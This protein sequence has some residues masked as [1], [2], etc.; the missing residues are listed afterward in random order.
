MEKPDVSIII[1]SFNSRNTILKTLKSLFR[2]TYQGVYEV[3]VVDSSTDGTG[4]LIRREFPMVRLFTF[5]ERKF[6]G[7]ARN[8]G[9]RQSTGEIIAFIDADCI[10]DSHWIE[11]IVLAHET[12][13]PVIGGAVGNGN[14][15]SYVGWAYY[16]CEFSQWMPNFPRREMAEIPTCC[17]SITRATF[18]N[19]GPFIEGVYCSDSAFHWRIAREGIRA[20]FVPS[21]MVS[22]INLTSF[23]KFLAHAP[24]HGKSFAQM[25][26]RQHQFSRNRRLAFALL[27]PSLPFLLFARTAKRAFQNRV[28]LRQ[29]ITSSPL[30]FLGLAA[31]SFGEFQ[32]YLNPEQ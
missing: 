28:Y 11:E 15:E 10:A 22:H 5:S 4:N 8:Y 21:I 27:S 2:Q 9:I 1:A 17:L 14:P 32:G 23:R 3:V 13:H 6:P 18:N 7:D 31:W 20:R 30:I 26:C 29:F 24:F 16:F 12:P 25:R 19:Y